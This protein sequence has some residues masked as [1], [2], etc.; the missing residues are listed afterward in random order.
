MAGAYLYRKVGQAVITIVLILLLNFLLFRAMPG[1]PE[2]ILFRNPNVTPELLAAARARWGLD[3]PIF[4]DQFVAYVGATVNDDVR[5]KAHA[6]AQAHLFADCAVRPD[7]AALAQLG[8]G[9]DDGGRM[10]VD[11]H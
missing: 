2:R 7:V 8:A 11:G 5:L 9:A 4:P 1:S 3:K 6:R 10:D